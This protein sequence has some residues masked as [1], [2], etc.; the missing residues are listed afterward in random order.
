MSLSS[1]GRAVAIGAP[2]NGANGEDSGHVRVY[3]ID[4]F[5][6]NWTQIGQDIDG[7]AAGDW[8]G[9]G[10]SVSLSANG[11]IVAIGAYLNNNGNGFNSGHVRIYKMDEDNSG[12]KQIGQDIDG[13]AAYDWSGLAVSLSADGKT[14]AIGATGNDG[15]GNGYNAGH[16][17]VYHMADTGSN[18][19]QLGEDIYGESAGDEAGSS[20][21]LSADGR[22]VA[23]GS[24]SND[25]NGVNSGHVRV[26]NQAASEPY[27]DGREDG[28]VKAEAEWSGDCSD[29]ISSRRK[30][31]RSVRWMPRW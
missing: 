20:V 2:R 1:D 3:Q 26:F 28:T 25:D 16:V 5:R 21:S 27:D 13:E 9:F 4:V 30:I 18:W 7:E 8:S 6:L 15:D 12:W 17:R 24:I 29:S 11:K 22:S 31:L 23:V 19:E 10:T 14:L